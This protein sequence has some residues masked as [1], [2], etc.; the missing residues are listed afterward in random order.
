MGANFLRSIGRTRAA[1]GI[2]LANLVY[3]FKRYLFL[4]AQIPGAG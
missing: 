2:G 4:K 3:N 1:V